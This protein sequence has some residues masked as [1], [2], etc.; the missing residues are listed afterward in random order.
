VGWSSWSVVTD[1]GIFTQ[2]DTDSGYL[3]LSA[4][5]AQS[6]RAA[7]SFR[8]VLHVAHHKIVAFRVVEDGEAPGIFEGD[9]V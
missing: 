6:I 1:D 3:R 8:N 7:Y 9:E 5:D 2:C 4:Q